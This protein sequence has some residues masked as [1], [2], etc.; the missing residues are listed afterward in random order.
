MR[1]TANIWIGIV[2][3]LW[4]GLFWI[5]VGLMKHVKTQH[6]AGYPA[7]GQIFYYVKVPAT[8]IVTLIFLALL[9]N[10]IRDRVLSALLLIAIGFAAFLGIFVYSLPYGGGV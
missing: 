9:V 1:I 3:A 2:C 6:V 7:A 5:G 4:A 10:L 8:M